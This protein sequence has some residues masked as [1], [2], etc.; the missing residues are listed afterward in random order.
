LIIITGGIDMEK[1]LNILH[2]FIYEAYY[3]LHLFSNKLNPFRLIHRLPFQRRRYEKLGIDI[4]QEI[5]KA[6]GDKENGLSIIVSGGAIVG[7]VFFLILA[8][9]ILLK[10]LLN[11]DL[12]LEIN[13]FVFIAILSI[14]P[15]YFSVFKN[16]RYLEHFK[17]YKKWSKT[18]KKKYRWISFGLIVVVF[19]FFI[20]SLML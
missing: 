1:Y 19:I 3:S 16:D 12:T 18:E 20:G 5:N 11:I 4:E 14:I 9:V 7:I 8:L 15:C 2:Y 17:E 13:H 10:Q 6:F